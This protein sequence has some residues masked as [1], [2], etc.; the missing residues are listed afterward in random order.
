MKF[1]IRVAALFPLMPALALAQ[2][3][4]NFG[5]VETFFGNFVDFINGTL[6]PLVFALAFL[7]FIWGVFK[8]FILGGGDEEKRAE[9]KQLMLWGII[10]FVVM[11]SVWGIVNI[12]STGLFGTT[13]NLQNIPNAPSTR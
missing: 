4:G 13:T 12:L 11:V 5:T 6:V 1:L 8:Y 9:G 2:S 7:M 3:V 10:A